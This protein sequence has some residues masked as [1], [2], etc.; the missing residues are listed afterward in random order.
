LG[1]D[2][3]LKATLFTSV[4]LALFS[5]AFAV[6][7]F[8]VRPLKVYADPGE[9]NVRVPLA[10]SSSDEVG[11][12]EILVSYDTLGG[13]ITRV[14]AVDSIRALDPLGD[15]LAWFHSSWSGDP[16]SRPEYLSFVPDADGHP[17]RVRVIA[18]M[19]MV[20]PP[21]VP[22]VSVGENIILFCF[23][24]N[25]N[26]SWQGDDLF[27]TFEAEQCKDNTLTDASGYLTWGPDTA[28]ADPSTCPQRDDTMR[29]VQLT[30]GPAIGVPQSV[31]SEETITPDSK[32][33]LGRVFPNPFRRTVTIPYHLPP[34]GSIRLTIWDSG[35]RLQ[36]TLLQG[37]DSGLPGSVRWDGTDDHGRLLP[38]GVYYCRALVYLNEGN[39][40]V[41]LQQTKKL[42]MV[43]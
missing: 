8:E 4:V 28:S 11:A 31:E 40:P 16:T 20:P 15:T 13:E 30:S 19:D 33:L 3:R 14:E 21:I 24:F 36:K 7:S 42:L 9:F 29:V 12:W 37:R 23:V 27:I 17:D 41:R 1:E 43:R 22:P 18:I 38:S 34:N 2:L 25:V 5:T 35:G 39:E 10:L 32:P 26:P 6:E